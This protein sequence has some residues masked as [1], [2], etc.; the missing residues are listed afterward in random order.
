MFEC[1]RNLKK[2][3]TVGGLLENA[4][5]YCQED[6][7]IHIGPPHIEQFS[8]NESTKVVEYVFTKRKITLKHIGEI[9]CFAHNQETD[10]QVKSFLDSYFK[11]KNIGTLEGFNKH[12]KALIRTHK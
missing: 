3:M 6:S 1:S 11:I 7:F 4:Y 8:N 10:A 9:E 5:T 2:Y 12:V